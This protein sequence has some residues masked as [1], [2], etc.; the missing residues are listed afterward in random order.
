MNLG[1]FCSASISIFLCMASPAFATVGCSVS[2]ASATLESVKLYSSPEDGSEV[3]REIPVGDIVLYPS[4]DLAPAQAD[5]WAWVRH[6][7][8]Q[9]DIWQSGKFGW[10]AVEN[11]SDCG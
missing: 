1:S 6:D 2:S 9:L 7:F 4:E 10:M 3:I 5:G 11:I 8:G